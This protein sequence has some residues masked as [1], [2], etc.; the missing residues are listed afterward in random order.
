[1][2]PERLHVPEP[3]CMGAGAR[4]VP[5]SYREHALVVTSHWAYRLA[6]QGA[7]EMVRVGLAG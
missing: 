7:R 2:A 1:M 6:K 3:F 5:D 4:F